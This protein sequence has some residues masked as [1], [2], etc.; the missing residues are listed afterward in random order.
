MSES[1]SLENNAQILLG[2]VIMEQVLELVWLIVLEN[3]IIK[4]Q[5]YALLLTFKR[6]MIAGVS[7]KSSSKLITWLF[8]GLIGHGVPLVHASMLFLK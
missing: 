5:K 8:P 6:L 4:L 3:S 2:D 1:S 7:E